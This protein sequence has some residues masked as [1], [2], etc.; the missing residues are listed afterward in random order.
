MAALSSQLQSIQ[1]EN[2]ELRARLAEALKSTDYMTRLREHETV[3]L[4]ASK[5]PVKNAKQIP[6]LTA[7]NHTQPPPREMF[8]FIEIIWILYHLI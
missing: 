6:T 8:V 5:I 7:D 3:G 2:I 1:S 4:A